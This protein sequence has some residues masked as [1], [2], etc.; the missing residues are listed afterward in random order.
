[1][2]DDLMETITGKVPKVEETIIIGDVENADGFRK[3][4]YKRGM[5]ISGYAQEILDKTPLS[6]KRKEIK[7]VIVSLADIGFGFNE[8]VEY[9]TICLRAKEMNLKQCPAEIGPQICL[10]VF[11]GFREGNWFEIASKPIIDSE[12]ISRLFSSSW[13]D[14]KL[15]LTSHCIGPGIT[16]SVHNRFAFV[17]ST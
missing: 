1:M 10:Q 11:K 16:Y 5:T 2:K 12:G 15:S 9:S 14:G 7:I 6:K 13:S 4:F 17:T 3:L 8:D